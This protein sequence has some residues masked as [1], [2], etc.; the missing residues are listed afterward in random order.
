MQRGRSADGVRTGEQGGIL[1][2]GEHVGHAAVYGRPV[3]SAAHR[4]GEAETP[5]RPELCA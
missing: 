3:R 5:A 4:E 1:V 2:Q